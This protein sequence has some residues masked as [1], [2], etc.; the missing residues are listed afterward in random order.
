MMPKRPLMIREKPSGFLSAVV[1]GMLHMVDRFSE[2]FC[3]WQVF[4]DSPDFLACF[5]HG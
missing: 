2:V 1:G 5:A 3:I 4:S